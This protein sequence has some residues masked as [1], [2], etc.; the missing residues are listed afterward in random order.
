[1]KKAEQYPQQE[2]HPEL[3]DV[4]GAEQQVNVL[5]VQHF[6]EIV[7]IK[8]TSKMEDWKIVTIVLSVLLSL[9]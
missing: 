9:L 2:P 7:D 3:H 4:G 5:L 8:F 1:M 6:P